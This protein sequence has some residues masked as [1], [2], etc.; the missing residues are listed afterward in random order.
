VYA[1][2]LLHGGKHVESLWVRKVAGMRYRVAAIPFYAY[3]VSLGDTVLCGRDEDGRGLFVERVLEKSGNRTVRVAFEAP[4][5]GKHAE[6][7]RLQEFLKANRFK[8]DYNRVQLFSINVPCEE[9]YVQLQNF[10]KQMPES[11]QMIWEDGDPEPSRN[12]DATERDPGA[13][14]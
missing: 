10:L 4:E 9:S 3:N 12:L 11:A 1:I 6:A 2:V 8:W 7:V 14:T 13:T 5:Q